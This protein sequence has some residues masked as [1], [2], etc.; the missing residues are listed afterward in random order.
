MDEYGMN[1][2][3]YIQNGTAHIYYMG[4]WVEIGK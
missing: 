3:G 4:G 2:V 1:R